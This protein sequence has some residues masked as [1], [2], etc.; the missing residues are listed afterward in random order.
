LNRHL[1]L[2]LQSTLS[3]RRLETDLAR[4]LGHARPEITVDIDGSADDLAGNPVRVE[5]P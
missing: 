5:F 2:P 1:P 4:V 3:Q